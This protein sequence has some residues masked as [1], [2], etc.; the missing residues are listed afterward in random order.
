M[1]ELKKRI[2]FM[3]EAKPST[4]RANHKKAM[5]PDNTA[6]GRLGYLRAIVMKWKTNDR[7]HTS[8]QRSIRRE[9]Y[10]NDKIMM[11]SYLIEIVLGVR[12]YEV[13]DVLG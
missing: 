8:R 13:L 12:T 5:L 6:D 7:T 4:T 2:G 10:Q 3:A 9:I 1:P 11:Q